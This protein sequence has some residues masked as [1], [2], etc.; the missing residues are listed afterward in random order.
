MDNVT[1][2]LAGLLLAE[3]AVR[4]RAR[5]SGEEPSPRFRVVAALSSMIAANLPDADLFYTGVGRDR[6]TYLLHHRGHTHTVVIAVL[7][8]ALLWL[9]A[10]LAL[11]PRARAEPARDEARLLFG[12]LLVSTLS[13]LALDWTN[14]YGVH[15]FWPLDNRWRYGDA[16][17][18]VEPWFWVIAVPALFA[19]TTRRVAQGLLA[20]VLLAGLALSWRVPQVMTGAAVA[21]TAGVMAWIVVL[22][23]L[24]PGTRAVAAVLAWV[25][26][27]LVMATGSAMAR[28]TVARAVREADPAAELLD[29]VVTPLPANP[30]CT[31]VITVERTSATYR[32][33]TARA[34]G[35][36]SLTDV[37]RC[38]AREGVGTMFGVSPRRATRAVQWDTEWTASHAELATLARESCPARAALRFI[39]V[40][41]WRAVA[42]STVMLGDVR[43]GGGSGSGFSDVRVPRRSAECP[44]AVPDWTPP[45]ADLLGM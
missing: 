20:A 22:R 6:L 43:Y 30:L 15:P 5:R 1:H 44:D 35:L 11:R 4:L 26:V 7:G 3:S 40:P 21:L 19:A 28:S 37:S 17:F 32:V 10:S 31:T 34:T 9:A 14:S 13:H 42:D 27:T 29:V 24:R 23:A 8:A 36:P 45:R 38:G 25:A 33:V 12:L 2:S 41:V 39:R 16:V 18:I